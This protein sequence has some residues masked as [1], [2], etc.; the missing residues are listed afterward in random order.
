MVVAQPSEQQY[1]GGSSGMC[2]CIDLIISCAKLTILQDAEVA[3]LMNNPDA[4]K[5]YD[6]AVKCVLCIH[7][8]N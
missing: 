6:V 8:L 5:L 7:H 3:S 2:C 1:L 4:F